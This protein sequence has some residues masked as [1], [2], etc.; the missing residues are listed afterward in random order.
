MLLFY[1]FV[2]I[3]FNILLLSWGCLLKKFIYYGFFLFSYLFSISIGF[4]FDIYKS[5]AKQ[6]V[7]EDNIFSVIHYL[8]SFFFD[9]QCSFIFHINIFA[10][11]VFFYFF[12]KLTK[13]CCFFSVLHW[14]IK[15][16]KSS[17][18]FYQFPVLYSCCNCWFDTSKAFGI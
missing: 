9:N 11:L 17:K 13:F 14:C 18:N 16:S 4:F 10:F 8:C 3:Q 7:N 1:C 12:L 5:F 6:R 15:C 2:P